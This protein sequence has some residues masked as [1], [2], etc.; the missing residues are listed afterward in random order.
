MTSAD[1]GQQEYQRAEQ[2]L[3]NG[4]GEE[5]LPEAVRLLWVAVEKGNN[6]AEVAL[7]EL[8]RRGQGVPKNCDQA[9]I[10]LSAAA[11]KG[12]AEA[13]KHLDELVREGCE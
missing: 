11:R 1:T 12:S 3:R 6:G 8:Y 5:E 2:I 7:A 9:R 4:G 10:L 13:Q